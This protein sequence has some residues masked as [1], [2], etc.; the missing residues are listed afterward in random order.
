[1]GGMLASY[2]LYLVW[3]GENPDSFAYASFI[4]IFYFFAF[5]IQS[6]F[7]LKEDKTW[8]SILMCILNSLFFFMFYYAQ[9]KESYPDF[10]GMFV[11][12]LSVLHM[13]SFFIYKA[14]SHEGMAIANKYLS[15]F[16][17]TLFIP[18]QLDEKLVTIIWALE[19]LV[20]TLLSIRLNDKVLK[21][22]SYIVGGF[23][24]IKTLFYD[25]YMLHKFDMLNFLDSTRMFSFLCTIICFSIIYA[26][27][28]KKL[29]QEEQTAAAIYSW[30]S[31]IL[32]MMMVFMELVNYSF[33]SSFIF[34][35][36]IFVLIILAKEGYPE[37]RYQAYLISLVLFFK[38]LFSD[39]IELDMLNFSF[40][41]ISQRIA[42]FAFGILCFYYMSYKEQKRE[43]FSNIYT[44]LASILLFSSVMIEME[45]YWISIGWSIVALSLIGYGIMHRSRHYRVQGIIIF[46][47]TIFKV[48]IYD[49][50]NLELIYRTVSYIALGFILLLVSFLY[51]KYKDRFSKIL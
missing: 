43:L 27:L 38:L 3:K 41:A 30:A 19:A 15:L 44:Y 40:I 39:S 35:A 2:F 32:F 21:V 25:S 31:V 33:M 20:L 5:F 8:K 23:A 11:I 46:S 48:F 6:F 45:E 4:L 28:K 9:I 12:S 24:A 29:A 18:I 13:V 1:F 51:T 42:I 50:R 26:V 36:A 16:Y 14:R 17:L 10:K 47:I 34:I 49:I 22:G 7:L 37:L